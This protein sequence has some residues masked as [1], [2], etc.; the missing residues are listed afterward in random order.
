MYMCGIAGIVSSETIQSS[1]I[2]KM[3]KKLKHR[4]PD[5]IQYYESNQVALGHTRLAIIDLQTGAQPMTREHQNETYTIVYNG[6]LYNTASLRDELERA[7]YSFETTSDTEVLL[8]A[9]IHWREKC[10]EKLD[11]IF[12]FAIWMEHEKQL[13]LARDRFG[14]K[15]LFYSVQHETF[16]FASEIKALLA[17]PKCHPIVTTEGL[18]TLLSIGPSRALGKT[19]YRDIY[20]V[21]PGHYGTVKKGVFKESSYYKLAER[22]HTDSLQETVANVQY[23]V[24]QAV[25]KQLVSDVPVCTYLSGGI[26]SSIISKVASE[27]IPLHTFSLTYVGNEAY[28]KPNEFQRSEDQPFVE[29]MSQFIQSEHHTVE[30]KHEHLFDVLIDAL[31]AK[32]YPSMADIDGALHLFSKEVARE[33]KVALSGECADELFGGYPWFQEEKIDFPWIQSIQERDELLKTEVREALKIRVKKEQLLEEA[34]AHVPQYSKQAT[35]LYLNQQYFMQTLLERKDRMTMAHG[36]EVRVPF[37]DHFL[38]EYVWNIPSEMKRLYDVEK[39]LLRKAFEEK[40]PKE[41]AW[42]KKNPFPK[43]HHPLYTQL[44]KEE[45]NKRFMKSTSILRQLFDEEKF[46]ELIE[47]GGVAFKKP[48]FGQ[49]MT[50]PQLLAYF[51]QLDEWYDRYEVQLEW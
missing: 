28:F 33:F 17:H 42:R 34:V 2:Q 1:I 40:I 23:L 14:V 18:A 44:V 51:I 5:A 8:Y 4:G 45:L 48:W 49:L 3:T 29:M 46:R 21:K 31:V 32:D 22:E 10:L 6:E 43:T 16:L 7:N 41:V 36:L 9:F 12:A 20:E 38:V 47:S 39:G 37:A 24:E 26:D 13:F 35:F 27:E 50:G 30:L 25:K 15:P 11:G 19:V